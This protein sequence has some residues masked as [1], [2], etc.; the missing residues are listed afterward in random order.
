M[1]VSESA[2][3]YYSNDVREKR[4]C[5]FYLNGAFHNIVSKQ[6][7]RKSMSPQTLIYS[8]TLVASFVMLKDQLNCSKLSDS[9]SKTA[10]L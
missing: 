7:Y 3:S 4:P 1:Q 10:N 5:V 9:F 6:L 8:C 2:A